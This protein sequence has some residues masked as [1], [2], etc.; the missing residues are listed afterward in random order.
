M[1]YRRSPCK[2]Y[3]P[4]LPLGGFRCVTTAGAQRIKLEIAQLFHRRSLRRRKGKGNWNGTTS[5]EHLGFVI[6]TETQVFKVRS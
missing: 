5:P 4:I 3:F 1:R 6:N 2:D